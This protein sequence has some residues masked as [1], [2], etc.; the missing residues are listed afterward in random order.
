MDGIFPKWAWAP[1]CQ[2][3]VLQ[4]ASLLQLEW[5]VQLCPQ[6]AITPTN[7]IFRGRR[8]HWMHWCWPIGAT[9][10]SVLLSELGMQLLLTKTEEL[11]T[12]FLAYRAANIPHNLRELCLKGYAVIEKSLMMKQCLSGGKILV[13]ML[14]EFLQQRLSSKYYRMKISHFRIP[15]LK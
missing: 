13:L 3:F 9:F 6:P 5:T 7:G 11:Y 15:N 14:N 10:F 12:Q 2:T 1:L 8:P 4:R